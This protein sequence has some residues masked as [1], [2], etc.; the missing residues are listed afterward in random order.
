MMAACKGR[1]NR[2]TEMVMIGLLREHGLTGWRRH[3][4]VI[5]KPDFAWPKLKVAMFVDGCFWH[6]CPYCRRAPRTNSNFWDQKIIV[7]QRRDRKVNRTLR[8]MGWHVVRVR[9]CKIRFASTINRIA[10]SM[11]LANSPAEEKARFAS[12]ALNGFTMSR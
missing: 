10:R 5:G 1:G 2:S 7:N 11:R 6:G 4:S 8:R 9:E 12:T 3:F